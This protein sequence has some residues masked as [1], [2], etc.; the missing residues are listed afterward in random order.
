MYF[1]PNQ[2]IYDELDKICIKTAEEKEHLTIHEMLMRLMDMEGMPMHCPYHHYI[3]PAAMLTQAAVSETRTMD[4]L[5][6][7]LAKAQERAKTVP[8]GFCGECGNCGA[9][10]GIGIFLSVHEGTTPKSV[11]DWQ[12]ANYITGLCLQKIS[13]FPGPR[14]CKRTAFIAV[15]TGVPYVN[16]KCGTDFTISEEHICKYHNINAE[17][18][19][20]ECPYYREEIKIAERKAVIVPDELLPR[21]EDENVCECMKKP[22]D[23][24]TKKGYINWVKNEGDTVR[25]GEV[26]C[27]IEVDKKTV[28]ITSSCDG[29]LA[30]KCIEDGEVAKAGSILG[31]LK[32]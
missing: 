21:A 15:E 1:E 23:L 18:I 6:E 5:N 3:I 19:E 26:I 10:T 2:E 28:D 29:I 9:A 8:A 4:E 25:Y 22:V 7:W 27:D 14:C 16:E 24:T 20:K 30:E 32:V 11:T 13:E 12:W 17:C 31:Y